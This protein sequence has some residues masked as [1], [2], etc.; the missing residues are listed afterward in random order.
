MRHH[1]STCSLLRC[2]NSLRHT[3]P[4][5]SLPA[6][7]PSVSARLK[8]RHRTR[9]QP[10]TCMRAVVPQDR[11]SRVALSTG[12]C[13]HPHNKRR[14]GT[15]CSLSP[16]RDT[17]QH[18][19]NLQHLWPQ[20]RRLYAARWGRGWRAPRGLGSRTP[21]G[22]AGTP[23]QKGPP[24]PHWRRTPR[25][26]MCIPRASSR[27][28]Q[29]WSYEDQGTEC[30]RHL[31]RLV[32]TPPL[33]KGGMQLCQRVANA[34]QYK[35]TRQLDGRMHRRWSSQGTRAQHPR[36]TNSLLDMA[37]TV[38]G[39][40]CAQQASSLQCTHSLQWRLPQHL[41]CFCLDSGAQSHRQGSSAQAG[42]GCSARR[43]GGARSS[44]GCRC[45]LSLAQPGT[46]G[47]RGS[48]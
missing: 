40:R 19:D 3:A 41:C 6:H 17:R 32:C 21:Q 14:L 35:H 24:L 38:R 22:T 9:N 47:G 43:G 36:R 42:R 34:Q 2:K 23:V 25:G 8:G 44:R 5:R 16:S 20:G 4:H 33:R 48:P 15:A 28:S 27:Q 26:R 12:N 45:S 30:I 29:Q 39:W 18:T 1:C 13:L 11:M 46:C 7:T 37:R 31:P 10:W